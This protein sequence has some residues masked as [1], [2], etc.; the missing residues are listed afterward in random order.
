MLTF[1]NYWTGLTYTFLIIF[2]A[3]IFVLMLFYRYRLIITEELF[4]FVSNKVSLYLGV[5][6]LAVS[7]AFIAQTD[8]FLVT[9]IAIGL[10]IAAII[11][12]VIYLVVH[13]KIIPKKK[14]LRE[15]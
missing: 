15:R 2:L 11:I 8:N 10:T 7:V 9:T 6:L 5:F 12:I 14:R 13:L 3:F 1:N 4:E